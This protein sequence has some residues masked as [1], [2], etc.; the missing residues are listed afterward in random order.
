MGKPRAI[1]L[2]L[3]EGEV[4]GPPAAP[5]WVRTAVGCWLREGGPDLGPALYPRLGHA[6]LPTMHTVGLDR[7]CR[8]I[9]Y[10]VQSRPLLDPI[11]GR[12]ILPQPDYRGVCPEDLLK[13]IDLF[14]RMADASH[15]SGAHPCSLA[16]FADLFDT[17]GPA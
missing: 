13:K 10:Y 6:L 1:E 7:L 17:R 4:K 5:P 15:A 9:A 8:A 11:S 16:E 12:F 3:F 14:L 2:D